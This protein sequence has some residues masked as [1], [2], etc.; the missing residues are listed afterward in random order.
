MK[1]WFIYL[2]IGLLLAV[3]ESSFLA[4]PFLLLFVWWV[5]EADERLIM[6]LILILGVV[7]DILM[8]RLIGVSAICLLV[9][10]A[11][12][13]LINQS[14]GGV[15]V[16]QAIYLFISSLLWLN[17]LGHGVSLLNLV[18]MESLLMVI[19]FMRGRVLFK[20]E[21]KLR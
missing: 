12:I 7:L 4:W 6:V 21:I 1:E 14:L 10:W 13:K 5:S 17:F 16:A 3:I 9:F 2:I 8:V 19:V 15:L 11:V 20:K 18:L